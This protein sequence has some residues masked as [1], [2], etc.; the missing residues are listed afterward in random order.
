MWFV[1]LYVNV[2]PIG[3]FLE[4]IG[5]SL[6][7]WVD[8]YNLLRRSSINSE[9]SG[10]L[11]MTSM[12]LLDLTLVMKPVGEIMFD[13]KIRNGALPTSIVMAIVGL[14]YFLLPSGKIIELIND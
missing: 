14:V 11:V 6:Y 3:T 9:V 13:A 12:K 1:F 5:L 4:V 7:Y 10:A 2:I 8:K